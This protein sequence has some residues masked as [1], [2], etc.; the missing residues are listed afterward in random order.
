[1]ALDQFAEGASRMMHRMALSKSE[2]QVLRQAN[3]ELNKRR[4]A[5]R[6]HLQLVGSLSL[7]KGQYLQDQK[8]LAQQGQRETQGG[9]GRKLK[10]DQGA[11]VPVMRWDTMHG[12]GRMTSKHLEKRFLRSLHQ[13]VLPWLNY[14]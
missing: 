1:M 13:F 3:K 4:R 2:V 11:V 8:N 5:K 6:T 14:K 9:S 10:Q 12:L 7:Q